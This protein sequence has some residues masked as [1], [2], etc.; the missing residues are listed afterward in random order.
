MSIATLFFPSMRPHLALFS[1]DFQRFEL[2]P[3]FAVSRMSWDGV[4]YVLVRERRETVKRHVFVNGWRRV[5][6]RLW[7]FCG[8]ALRIQQTEPQ[9]CTRFA[10]PKTAPQEPSSNLL[11]NLSDPLKLQG[12]QAAAV[13]KRAGFKW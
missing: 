3:Y 10:S 12:F 9:S 6:A 1:P 8:Q 5:F 13:S 2:D 11:Q 4:E 7:G